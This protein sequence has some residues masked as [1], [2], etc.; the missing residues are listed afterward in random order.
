MGESIANERDV[1]EPEHQVAPSS[2]A[3]APRSKLLGAELAHA[4]REAGLTQ[5]E[6]ADRVG[7]RLWMV[8][9][10][11]AG[12][13]AIPHDTLERISEAIG[14]PAAAR[15]VGRDTDLGHRPATQTLLGSEKTMNDIPPRRL[16]AQEIRDAELPKSLRGY[17]EG[18]TRRLLGDAAAAYERSV[19]QVDELRRQLEE[20]ESARIDPEEHEFLEAERDELRERVDQLSKSAKSGVDTDAIVSER[21]SLAAERDSLRAERDGLVSERDE[22]RKRADEL[23]AE[24]AERERAVAPTGEQDELRRRVEELEQTLAGYAESE[25][26]LTRALVAASRAGEEL[27]KEAEA[28]AQAILVDAR[29]AAEEIAREIDDRRGSFESE[30]AALVEDLKHEALASA[31]DDLEALGR[32]A[33]P[34]LEALAVLDERIRAIVPSEPEEKAELLEDLKAAPPARKAAATAEADRA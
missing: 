12:A 7:V 2:D 24:L 19:N 3:S 8:D 30:R 11:E 26:A 4:R 32:A 31:R 27:V 22:L 17:E 28:E 9:Q 20:Q 25:Q 1:L 34:V 13:K 21:D 18:A 15:I 33:K 23:E 5:R 6:L 14:T 10:W 16:T 29:R